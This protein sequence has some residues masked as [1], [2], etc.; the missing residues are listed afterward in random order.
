MAQLGA[1]RSEHVPHHGGAGAAARGTHGNT[2]V[3]L[4]DGNII[5]S[6]RNLSVVVV[7]RASGEISWRLGAPPLA[8]QHTPTPLPN[9]N[10]LIFDN[11][12]HRADMALPFSR[13]IE[14]EMATK[15]IVWTY[16]ARPPIDFWIPGNVPRSV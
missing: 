15:E 2:V 10:L 11:G 6:F 9:G 8:H 12:T 5:V 3:E 14:V 7:D 1:S 13:V 4:P 16:E